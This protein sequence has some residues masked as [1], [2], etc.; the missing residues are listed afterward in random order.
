MKKPA[1]LPD[2]SDKF[3]SFSWFLG[4]LGK[5]GGHSRGPRGFRSSCKTS[6]SHGAKAC[7]PQKQNNKESQLQTA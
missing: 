5:W 2:F 4:N 3:H 7:P 6:P 1:I